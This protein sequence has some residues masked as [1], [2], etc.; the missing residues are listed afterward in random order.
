MV[1][2]QEKI[3]EVKKIKKLFEE[4]NG[5]IFTDHSGLKAGDAVIVRDKLVGM[6]SYLRIIK[7]TLALI[8]A[9]D[10][11]RD[12]RFDE[13]LIGPTSV[14]VCQ[15]DFASTAKA[16]TEFSKKLEALKIKAAIMDGVFLDPANVKIIAD[17][18][19]REVLL[20]DLARSMKAPIYQLVNILGGFSRNLVMVLNAIK[21]KKESN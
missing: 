2:K 14:V 11:F 10:V 13:V 8:A 20:A 7:N 16:I 12:M 18:P 15:K 5:L 3:D 21:E 19:S 17:L 1:P 4:N 6:D 9:R